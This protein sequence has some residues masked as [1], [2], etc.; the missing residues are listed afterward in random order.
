MCSSMEDSITEEG[1]ALGANSVRLAKSAD[2]AAKYTFLVIRAPL[3]KGMS[4]SRLVLSIPWA[5]VDEALIVAGSSAG[6]PAGVSVGTWLVGMLFACGGPVGSGV[7]WLVRL[8]TG[9]V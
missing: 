1:S 5:K 9:G 8:T 2:L 3:A 4:S 6:V 7:T